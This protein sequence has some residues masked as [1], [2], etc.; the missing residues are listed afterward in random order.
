M[1]RRNMMS[2]AETTQDWA[3]QRGLRLVFTAQ[4]GSTNDDAKRNAMNETGDL[5]LYLT[6]HQTAGRGRGSNQWLDTGAGEG[7]LST[8]SFKV[9]TPPQAITAPRI[10][11]ALFTAASRT[12]PSLGWG[13]KAPNDLYLSRSKA[14]GL[15]IES[16]S[17]GPH[18]RLLIGLGFN[19]ANHPRSFGAATHLTGALGRPPEAGE[20]FK[21][22]DELKQQM[23]TA[24]AE[25]LRATLTEHACGELKSALNA[26]SARPFTVTKV[27]PQGDLVHA[28]GTVKWTDL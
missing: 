21:F 23:Q 11:L 2:A 13:L 24:A 5:V 22:L 12:W 20:W 8:W 9:P 17:A 25:C 14:A 7:L 19:V 18:H 10:G 6:G 4:T 28:G 16:V 3:K 27:S 15:L 1:G 26:N